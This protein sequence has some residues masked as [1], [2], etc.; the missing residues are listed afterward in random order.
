MMKLIRQLLFQPGAY[1]VAVILWFTVL[2]ERGYIGFI[3]FDHEA[4]LDKHPLKFFLSVIAMSALFYY[5]LIKFLYA[6]FH[7]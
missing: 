1:I 6:Q 3:L 4:V 5:L 7:N 2:I